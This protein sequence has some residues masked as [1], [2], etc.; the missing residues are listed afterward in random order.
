MECDRKLPVCIEC[1]QKYTGAD[2]PQSA[3]AGCDHIMPGRF[4]RVDALDGF[5]KGKTEGKR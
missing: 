5:K 3:K 4:F 2:Q 1:K